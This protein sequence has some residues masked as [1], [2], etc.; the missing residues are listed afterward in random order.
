M[1]IKFVEKA[2]TKEQVLSLM[3]PL[4]RDWFNSKFKEL[5]EP[6]ALAIPLI[7]TQENALISSPTGSGKT[8]TAFLSIINELW[9]LQEKGKLEDQIYAVYISPLKALA[10]DIEKNL[11]R[12]LSELRELAASRGQKGPEIRVGV[13]SG[14]TSAYE[15]QKQAK[16]PPHLFITTPESLSIVLS[17][18]KFREKFLNV[19]YLIIDEI[20]E[21]CSSKRGVL[22]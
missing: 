5:T 7:H 21:V 12:P 17:S 18:P 11:E 16:R 4:V 19:R 15:R 3:H 13:R 6:Q 22:M 10:N 14:D 2:R 9:V 20:H 8:L 1:G